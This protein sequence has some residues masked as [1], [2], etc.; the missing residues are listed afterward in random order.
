MIQGLNDKY[1]TVKASVLAQTV[2]D[3]IADTQELANELGL[4][5]TPQQANE[6]MIPVSRVAEVL[7]AT[8]IA[9]NLSICP[10][11]HEG[12]LEVRL[13]FND[14]DA[15]DYCPACKSR[16]VLNSGLTYIDC[17]DVAKA[18]GIEL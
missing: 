3:A 18:L 7:R 8:S 5:P 4:V 13:N 11:C 16:H 2:Q 6:P 10:S 17:T 1:Y 14:K 12:I 9:S 15:I